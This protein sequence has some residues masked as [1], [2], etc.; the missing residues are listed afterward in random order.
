MKAAIYYGP[1]NLKVEEIERPKAG[2]RG[3]VV[4]VRAAGICGSDLHPYKQAWERYKTGIALG[5]EWAGDVV[6]VGPKVTDVKVGDRV[7]ATAL[8]PDFTCDAC[9]R[10]AYFQCPNIKVG[11]LEFHGGFAEYVWAPVIIPNLN[12]F[13]LPASMSYQD[14]A[15]IEPVAVGTGLVK[16]AEPQASDVVAILGA[17]IIGLGALARFRD[18]GISRIIVSD[19]SEKRLRVARELGADILVNPT[20]EDIIKRVMKETN[21]RGADIVVEAAGRP[22]T[23]LQSIDM[24]RPDGKIMVVATYEESFM[25]NP[26]LAR[27]G[28]PMTSLVRKA[29]RMFG[30]YAGDMPSS[31]ELLKAGKIKASQVI[32]HTFPLNKIKEA[33]ETQMNSQESVKV[34]IEP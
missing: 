30:C 24:V 15:L 25:F 27:P 28:M 26:S 16:K 20:K 18:V 4:K 23:F 7:W 33:F 10:Q 11:G 8:L 29:V 31:F 9:K 14:G 3:I 19:V 12:L 32:S 21:N 17:G 13:K 6:E 22:V 34:M 2:D 5:H 1:G